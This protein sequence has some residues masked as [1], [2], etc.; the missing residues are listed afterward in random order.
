MKIDL[1]LRLRKKIG[2]TCKKNKKDQYALII[3]RN[4]IFHSTYLL[5]SSLALN[6]EKKI[7]QY[8]LN[9]RHLSKSENDLFINFGIEP[10]KY[11]QSL[12]FFQIITILF[13]SVFSFIKGSHMIITNDFEKFV[14]SFKVAEINIG[15]LVFDSYLRY[16]H[17]FVNPKFDIYLMYYLFLGVYK[18]LLIDKF[19]DKERL[20]YLIISGHSYANTNG[21]STRVALK[22]KITVIFSSFKELNFFTYEKIDK[23][24]HYLNNTST[25]R[26]MK[27]IPYS[28]KKFLTFCKLR[29][30]S[31][32]DSF[33]TKRDLLLA[34][35]N[36][37]KFSREQFCKKIKIDIN[38]YKK[39]VVFAPHAFSDAAHSLGRIFIFSDYFS[40]FKQTLNHIKKVE[41]ILWIVRPHPSSYIYGEKGIVENYVKEIN[42][43]NIKICPEKINTDNLVDITDGVVT[44]RGKIAL[45]FASF[46]KPAL[47]A[48][49]CS[50]SDLGFLCEPKNKKEYMK[51]LEKFEKIKPLKKNK[52]KI[53]RKASMYLEKYNENYVF[54]NQLIPYFKHKKPEDVIA[55]INKNLNKKY[56][57]LKSNYF[58]SISSRIKNL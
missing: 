24:R 19:F 56:N 54:K 46:G 16:N 35:G 31:K 18:T 44:G 23:G 49:K 7:N 55:E 51:F 36:K 1:I 4:R 9:E 17:R 26:A 22:K 14:K 21:I 20:K 28:E 2:L 12:K 13:K 41:D 43:H 27:K 25:L 40:H 32:S 52:I 58:I 39:I 10:K 33:T 29:K 37:K 34:Y 48:G 57:F 30:K 50:F 6:K 45:E 38:E 15:D 5:F 3:G 8:F 11:F 53:A 47:I 42:C